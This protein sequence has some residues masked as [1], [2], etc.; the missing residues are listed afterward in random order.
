MQAELSH[1]PFEILVEETTKWRKRPEKHNFFELVL[2]EQ[3]QGRQCINYQFVPYQQHSIF[4]LPPLNCHSFEVLTPTR[5]LFV[6]FTNQV[7]DK[8]RAGKLTSRT[9]FARCPTSWST[10]TGYPATSSAP[11]PTRSTCFTCCSWCA[12]STPGTTGS[13]PA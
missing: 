8:S 1:A 7:F 13:R 9:G 5:F 11:A 10:T 6:R 12:T 3:G 2:V 4:L